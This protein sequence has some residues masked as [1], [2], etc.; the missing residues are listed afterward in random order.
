MVENVIEIGAKLH[1]R[2]IRQ[3]ES[4]RQGQVYI[5]NAWTANDVAPAIAERT[6]IWNSEGRRI[7]KPRRS[8]TADIRIFDQVRAIYNGAPRTRN[9]LTDNRRKRCARPKCPESLQ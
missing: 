3:P 5:L 1:S 4:S 6:G 2:R 9:I 7:K 8:R